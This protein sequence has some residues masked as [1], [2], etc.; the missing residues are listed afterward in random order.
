MVPISPIHFWLRPNMYSRRQ[1]TGSREYGLSLTWN[2][3][4]ANYLFKSLLKGLAFSRLM[5]VIEANTN[6]YSSKEI[7]LIKE[8]VWSLLLNL[9]L[10][11]GIL[12]NFLSDILLRKLTPIN[13]KH[14]NPQLYSSIRHKLLKWKSYVVFYSI[15]LTVKET[16]EA[17]NG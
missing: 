7:A 17:I 14:G 2:H 8:I 6:L 15:F 11:L 5:K 13:H 10:I 1:T 3:C 4:M 12:H 9:G 16:D